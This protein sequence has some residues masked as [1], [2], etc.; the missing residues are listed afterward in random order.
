MSKPV[1]RGM[2]SRRPPRPITVLRSDR[3]L[4]SSTRRQVM[5][6]GSNAGLVAVIEVGIEHGRA[7]VVGG[8]DRMHVAGQVQVEQLHRHDLAVAAAGRAAL[9]AERRPHRGLADGDGGRRADVLERLAEADRRGGL[10][11]SEW[12]R[13]DGGDHDVLGPRPIGH[14]LDGVEAD[15]GRTRR[16]RARA[17]SRGIPA[18]DAMSV[19]RF[20]VALLW[21]SRDRW[22]RTWRSLHCRTGLSSS[23]CRSGNG[24]LGSLR[25]NGLGGPVLVR[26]CAG[27]GPRRPSPDR[28]CAVS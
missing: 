7:Q 5:W 16:R 21:R 3:S 20:E 1:S 12:G 19:E 22:E 8:G 18:E 27:T 9:D 2:P 17:S 25:T 6:C 14:G 28:V 23:H 13:R 15:L 24:S 26:L 10:A 4:T 11:L